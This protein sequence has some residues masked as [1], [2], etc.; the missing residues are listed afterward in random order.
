MTLRICELATTLIPRADV[1]DT[2]NIVKKTN[3]GFLLSIT[4]LGDG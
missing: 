1:D 4:V 3:S 2:E